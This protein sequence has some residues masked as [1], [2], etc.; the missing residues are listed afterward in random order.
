[1]KICIINTNASTY[2]YMIPNCYAGMAYYGRLADS[3]IIP[4]FECGAVINKKYAGL[5]KPDRIAGN[6]IIHRKTI[7][8]DTF[9]FC[10]N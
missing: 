2:L 6:C 1:M 3:N 10:S 7:P 9:A 5:G 8:Y 4:D